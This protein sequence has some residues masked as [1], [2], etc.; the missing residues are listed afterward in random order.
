M[1]NA[2]YKKLKREEY[3]ARME[4][5]NKKNK[6]AKEGDTETKNGG[7]EEMDTSE[8]AP[9]KDAIVKGALFKIANI[10]ANFSREE[11]KLKWYEATNEEDFKVHL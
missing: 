3:V 8:T 10:P 1:T 2:D 11:F 9:P 5:R 7:K 4:A 6:A